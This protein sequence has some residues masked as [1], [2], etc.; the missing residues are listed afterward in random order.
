V[1]VADVSAELV[2]AA[3]YEVTAEGIAGYLDAIGAAHRAADAAPPLFPVVT[4]ARP[5]WDVIELLLAANG[6]PFDR[7]PIVHIHHDMRVASLVRAGDVLTTEA[8][9]SEVRVDRPGTWACIDVESRRQDGSLVAGFRGLCLLLGAALSGPPGRFDVRAP[10]S[11]SAPGDGPGAALVA[12]RPVS[13]DQPARYARATGDVNPIHLDDAAARAAGLP[14]VVLHG[15]AALAI[16]T[17]I[18]VDAVCGGDQRAVR[19]VAARFSKPIV[20]GQDVAVELVP[21]GPGRFEFKVKA[22]G[23]TVIKG[24]VLETDRRAHVED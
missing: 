21:G 10:S 5:C 3:D 24:G 8:R 13:L 15:M 12:T 16:V 9:V 20:P 18:A 11:D 7:H 23:A 14:G 4:A 22:G 19:R 6:V 1:T 17:D 2:A